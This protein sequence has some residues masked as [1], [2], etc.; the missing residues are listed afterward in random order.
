[1]QTICDEKGNPKKVKNSVKNIINDYSEAN[2]LD[3]EEKKL[4]NNKKIIKKIS[5]KKEEVKL[6][7]YNNS[8]L[9]GDNISIE[10]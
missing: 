10:V 2:K 1:L 4:T 3:T 7:V 8:K 6:F 5:D 9:E